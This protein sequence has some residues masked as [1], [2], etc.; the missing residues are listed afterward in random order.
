MAPHR[1]ERTPDTPGSP[2]RCARRACGGAGRPAGATPRAGDA[3]PRSPR[4]SRWEIDRDRP[5]RGRGGE[6]GMPACAPPC[7]YRASMAS[8]L[9]T[10]LNTEV[11][12]N[13]HARGRRHPNLGDAHDRLAGAA[14]WKRG[15]SRHATIASSVSREILAADSIGTLT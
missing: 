15:D 4:P 3:A 7:A 13:T 2:G 8:Y 11:A 9:V 14:V 1:H 6:Q 12:P 5:S 10:A